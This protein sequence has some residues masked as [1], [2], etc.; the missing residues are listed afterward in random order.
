[1][2]RLLR[3]SLGAE[4]TVEVIGQLLGEIT[5]FVAGALHHPVETA[6]KG[7]EERIGRVDLEIL[8]HL[9]GEDF[10]ELTIDH[11]DGRAA[12]LLHVGSVKQR[13]DAQRLILCPGVL[14]AADLADDVPNHALV[15]RIPAQPAD[16][17]ARTDRSL[18]NRLFGHLFPPLKKHDKRTRGIL[19]YT[20]Y[21]ALGKMSSQKSWP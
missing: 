21:L 12:A 16:E 9:D 8:E 3:L 7:A 2:R 20:P 18:K 1:M 15:I 14:G 19:L 17:L 6:L 5:Q 11:V 13:A 4:E 10:A